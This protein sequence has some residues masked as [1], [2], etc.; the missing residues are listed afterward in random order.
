[1]VGL[2]RFELPTSPLS[3]VRSNQ[4]SYRPTLHRLYLLRLRLASTHNARFHSKILFGFPKLLV[5]VIRL[6]RLHLAVVLRLRLILLLVL[7]LWI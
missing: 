4:L 7:L 1:M 3:G 2:G 6:L 5:A